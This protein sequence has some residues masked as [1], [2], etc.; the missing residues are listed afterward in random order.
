MAFPRSV[1]LGMVR[2]ARAGWLGG[3][4][5]GPD[6][7]GAA[8]R[9]GCGVVVAVASVAVAAAGLAAVLLAAT[10]PPAVLFLALILAIL[11]RAAANC[12]S[13]A[14]FAAPMN[15][16]MV[17]RAP[18]VS[19]SSVEGLP[20]LG[21]RLDIKLV[22]ADSSSASSAAGHLRCGPHISSRISGGATLTGGSDSP[23]PSDGDCHD[24][25]PRW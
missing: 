8:V 20:A 15:T 14:F 10:G 16:V 5:K 1:G 23:E 24:S 6:G 17:C 4:A 19:F 11:A 13:A 18:G 12:A 9:A 21:G 2:A 3:G 25:G 22:S 7:G